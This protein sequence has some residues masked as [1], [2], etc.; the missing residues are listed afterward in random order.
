MATR[1]QRNR[2]QVEALPELPKRRDA[3]R[4]AMVDLTLVAIALV[5]GAVYYFFA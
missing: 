4:D 2:F 3:K 1:A 5:A